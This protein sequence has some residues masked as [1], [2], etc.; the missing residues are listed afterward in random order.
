[1]VPAPGL[2]VQ[3]RLQDQLV[4]RTEFINTSIPGVLLALHTGAFAVGVVCGC[5]ILVSILHLENSY[6]NVKKY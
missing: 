1:M 3:D 6:V 4:P 5:V 2:V